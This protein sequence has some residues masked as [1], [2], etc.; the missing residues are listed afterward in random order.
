MDLAR[1]AEVMQ[2]YA[3]IQVILRMVQLLHDLIQRLPVFL[4]PQQLLHE[5]PQGALV[6]GVKFREKVAEQ[7]GAGLEF[8]QLLGDIGFL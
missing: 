6:F 3:T 2:R 8:S 1:D 4:A 5:C 7:V